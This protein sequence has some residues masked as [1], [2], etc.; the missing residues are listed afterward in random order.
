MQTFQQRLAYLMESYGVETV[1]TLSRALGYSIS[2]PVRQVM[3]GSI[4]P[5]WKLLQ[6]LH[7][8]FQGLNMQWLVTGSGQMDLGLNQCAPQ[9]GTELDVLANKA[10]ERRQRRNKAPGNRDIM[11]HFWHLPAMVVVD[12]TGDPNIVMIDAQAAAGLPMNYESPAYYQNKPTLKLPGQIYHNGTFIAIEVIGDSMMPTIHSKDWLIARH[13]ENPFDQLREGYVHV[14]VAE[15]GVVAKR[16]YRADDGY[17][18]SL[19][20]DNKL[21]PPY[22]LML[23]EVLQLYRVEAIFSENL[24]SRRDA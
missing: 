18:L 15:E 14:V 3:N 16:L 19:K 23:S 4:D 12:N 24:T 17:S 8:N 1:A 13:L 5:S 9:G 22:K 11:P 21:Y 10:A 20:S 6:D 2:A 7:R